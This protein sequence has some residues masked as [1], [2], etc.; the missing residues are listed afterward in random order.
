ML[1]LFEMAKFLQIGAP[2]FQKHADSGLIREPTGGCG[3]WPSPHCLL[4]LTCCCA[5][6]LPR[7]LASLVATDPNLLYRYGR[8]RTVVD[9]MP[10]SVALIAAGF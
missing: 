5:E 6:I 10:G 3:P 2:A 4:Q 8:M 9:R 1:L 7:A